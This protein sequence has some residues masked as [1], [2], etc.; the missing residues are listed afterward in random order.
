MLVYDSGRIVANL[1]D[2]AVRISWNSTTV[3]LITI[4]DRW[5]QEGRT[6]LHAGSQVTSATNVRKD[7]HAVRSSLQDRT[8][9]SQ[10]LFQEMGLFA[11]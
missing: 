8:T 10:S 2:I 11:A 3:M 9:T 5:V 7:R 1:C 4:M 6:E